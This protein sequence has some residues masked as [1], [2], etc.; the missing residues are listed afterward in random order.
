[1]PFTDHYWILRPIC[2]F[3]LS[4]FL[5]F[6]PFGPLYPFGLFG[7]FSLLGYFDLFGLFATLAFW[8]LWSLQNCDIPRASLGPVLFVK[9]VKMGLNWP[10]RQNEVGLIQSWQ[11]LN[12]LSARPGG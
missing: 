7:F 6:R 9:V 3:G 1:M 5:L 12:A 11:P 8:P 2:L 10:V 4:S